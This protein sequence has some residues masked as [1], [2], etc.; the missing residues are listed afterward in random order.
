[1]HT[2]TKDL[3]F[4]VWGTQILFTVLKLLDHVLKFENFS[5]LHGNHEFGKK[6]KLNNR[7]LENQGRND[8]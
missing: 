1:M 5:T 7:Y 8:E 3:S 6:H 4:V 2:S